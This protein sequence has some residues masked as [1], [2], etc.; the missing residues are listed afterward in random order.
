MS[1]WQLVFR[2]ASKYS[3]TGRAELLQLARTDKITAIERAEHVLFQRLSLIKARNKAEK[4]GLTFI[5]KI[6]QQICALTDEA[7]TIEKLKEEAER[8]AKEIEDMRQDIERTQS[9]TAK[10]TAQQ[11]LR[12]GVSI[13]AATTGVACLVSAVLQNQWQRWVLLVP[14][15]LSLFCIP[16]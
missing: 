2:I 12:T 15:A 11:M 16:S 9:M 13:A 6:C 8:T 1:A 5:E 4:E 14:L 3:F 7:A 10:Q